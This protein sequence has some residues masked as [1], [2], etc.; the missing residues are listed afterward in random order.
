MLDLVLK[1]YSNAVRLTVKGAVAI[2]LVALAVGLPQIAHI[3]GGAAAGAKW[4]PMYLPVL[5][6]GCLLGWHWGL[7]IGILSPIISYGFTTLA[8]SSAMPTLARLP[9]MALELAAFGGVSGAFC[10]LIEK[11]SLFAFPAVLSAQVAGRAVY[12]IYNLIA[13]KGF[14][15]LWQSVETGLAGLY[16]QAVLV[17]VAVI[18]VAACIKRSKQQ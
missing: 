13:G 12:L 6:A 9:Y 7:G 10:K 1:K 11:N 17:P 16:L 3:A 8:L 2:V 14:A 4:M 18:V 15:E 5:L